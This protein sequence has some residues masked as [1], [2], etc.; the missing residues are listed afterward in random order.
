MKLD[1]I[2]IAIVL[3]SEVAA[4][5]LLTKEHN[6]NLIADDGG[7]MHLI[8]T[9]ISVTSS[10]EPRFVAFND[11]VFRL[12]TRTNPTVAQII[13]IYNDGQLTSSAFNPNHLTRLH[14]HGTPTTY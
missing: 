11:V 5:P 2:L 9:A 6:W 8:D 3:A 14:I 1:Y 13:T 4:S 7:R 12:F 10:N